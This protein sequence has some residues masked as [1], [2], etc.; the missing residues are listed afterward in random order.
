MGADSERFV[1]HIQCQGAKGEEMRKE[2]EK[3]RWLDK[4][5]DLRE[6][7]QLVILM[8]DNCDLSKGIE[9][10]VLYRTLRM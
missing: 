6:G 9:R 3:V 10:I 7:V 5:V 2:C 1:K 4:E 8:Y